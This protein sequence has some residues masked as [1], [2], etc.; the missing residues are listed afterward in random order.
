MKTEI[1]FCKLFT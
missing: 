1:Q